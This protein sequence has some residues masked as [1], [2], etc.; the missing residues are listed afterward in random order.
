MEELRIQDYLSALQRDPEFGEMAQTI[1]PLYKDA[2][3]VLAEKEYI[4][5]LCRTVLVGS[6]YERNLSDVIVRFEGNVSIVARTE[7]EFPAKVMLSS[8]TMRKLCLAW[9][10]YEVDR[11]KIKSK[12]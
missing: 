4:G 3:T 12:E 10:Q 8:E 5:E 9:L 6:L 11:A 1:L 7:S 2:G